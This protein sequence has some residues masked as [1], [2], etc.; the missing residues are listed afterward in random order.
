MALLLPKPF[1]PIDLSFTI[2]T[3]LFCL[4]IQEADTRHFCC[5]GDETHL[6]V[7]CPRHTCFTAPNFQPWF[8]NVL[9]E[10]L[11][12]EARVLFPAR[13]A[14]WS[15]RTGLTYKRLSIK[16][17]SSKWG[18]Y[19]SLGNINLSLYLLLLPA[20]CLDYT[21]CHELCHS[22]EMNHSPR[23]WSLLA[24]MLGQDPKPIGKAMNEQVRTWYQEEDP[25]YL[26]I[27][28]L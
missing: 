25:R 12:R 20:R 18:S 13:V 22:R 16:K 26:L 24:Q 4:D 9:R 17:T 5:K 2:Q 8:R 28:N 1:R 7:F 10:V 21:I 6:T 11:R 19:S 14:M 3:D 15:Q 23:F 27:S